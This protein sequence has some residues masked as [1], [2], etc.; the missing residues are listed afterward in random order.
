MKVIDDEITRLEA[1]RDDLH[2]KVGEGLHKGGSKK[3]LNMSDFQHL[4]NSISSQV[5]L[6]VQDS[7]DRI[8]DSLS[9]SSLSNKERMLRE[10]YL[11]DL[12][13][14]YS[15]YCKS[16]ILEGLKYL[17]NVA[18]KKRQEVN[19]LVKTVASLKVLGN[20]ENHLTDSEANSSA[21]KRKVDDMLDAEYIQILH[22]L[23]NFHK[24]IE[25]EAEEM[26]MKEL[27]NE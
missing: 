3:V 10:R 26:N 15:D 21:G 25:A 11:D 17:S 6:L 5:G 8:S 14:N 4:S 16:D 18:S 23:Y 20:L 2:S 13:E 1:E 12:C 7:V 19:E 9:D 22:E 27:E 24:G